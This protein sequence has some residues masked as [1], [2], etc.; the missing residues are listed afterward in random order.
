[1]NKLVLIIVSILLV[2]KL[3]FINVIIFIKYFI[4]IFQFFLLKRQQQIF[5]NKKVVI[6]A[7]VVEIYAPH[8]TP[9]WFMILQMINPV[10]LLKIAVELCSVKII[11]VPLVM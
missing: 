3:S 4:L 9:L 2:S 11:I 1:M 6:I 5:A 7:L 10:V 8:Q